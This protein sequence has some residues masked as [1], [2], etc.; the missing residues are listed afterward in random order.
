[1]ICFH[2][3]NKKLKAIEL[4]FGRSFQTWIEFFQNVR[5]G[6]FLSPIIVS[7]YSNGRWN[8]MRKISLKNHRNIP[9]CYL[10]IV[11]ICCIHTRLWTRL[12]EICIL[13]V[14]NETPLYSMV[15]SAK[16]SAIAPFPAIIPSPRAATIWRS[17]IRVQ[18]TYTHL[19]TA[20][21][22]LYR[23]NL[24]K[25]RIHRTYLVLDNEH[26]LVNRMKIEIYG[27]MGTRHPFHMYT[28]ACWAVMN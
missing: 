26:F 3:V 16:L 22:N 28:A 21:L 14:A 27:H 13:P 9:L 5:N 4:T 11:K 10:F 6:Q 2:D 17:P 20:H 15:M 8:R 12:F 19:Y 7:S 25:I 23:T 18:K 1:M 24:Y